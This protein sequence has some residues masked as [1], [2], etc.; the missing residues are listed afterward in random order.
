LRGARWLSRGG[1]VALLAAAS[2]GC[3]RIG[4]EWIDERPDGGGTPV[5]VD[6][7]D[8]GVFDA[9]WLDGPSLL[10]RRVFVSSATL[11]SGDFGGN[12]GGDALCQSLADARGLGGA[13]KAWLSDASQT[14]D[15]RFAQAAVPYRL[16]DGSIVAAD[17]VE[18]T[19]GTLRHPVNL[20]ENGAAVLGQVWT[21]TVRNGRAEGDHCTAWST[22]AAAT[23]GEAGLST[24]VN[25]RWT[26]AS[27]PPCNSAALHLYCFEQ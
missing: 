11:A 24:E 27:L 1:L 8:A 22:S 10:T 21:G 3:G 13:W 25:Y 20:D 2:V 4:Y 15:N 9:A 18:L 19:S 23:L 7:S 5:I 17:W 16:M 14:P 12:A 26:A 6:A